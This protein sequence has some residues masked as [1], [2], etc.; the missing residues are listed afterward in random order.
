MGT[1]VNANAAKEMC[2]GACANDTNCTAFEVARKKTKRGKPLQYRCEL[3]TATVN[4][5]AR[6]TKACKAA[7]CFV[8][9]A[10]SVVQVTAFSLPCI[11]AECPQVSTEANIK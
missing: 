4:S 10:P 2:A 11:S 5:A 6:A 9:R 8:K 3:H 7:Q 1:G